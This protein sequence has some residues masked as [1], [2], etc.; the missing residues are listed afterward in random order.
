MHMYQVFS[1]VA[2]QMFF[3][4]SLELIRRRNQ[5]F[6]E[7]HKNNLRCRE[8]I[9]VNRLNIAQLMT[10]TENQVLLSTKLFLNNA[11]IVRG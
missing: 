1:L 2:S 4:V 6:I 8:N 7:R 9:Y 10:K 3:D 5:H 11:I